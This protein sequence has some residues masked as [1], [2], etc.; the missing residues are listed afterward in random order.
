M[1]IST[2]WN[3][4]VGVPDGLFCSKIEAHSAVVDDTAMRLE[5]RKELSLLKY[6]I[7]LGLFTYVSMTR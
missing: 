6:Y 7:T 3:E 4:A 1:A 5:C 2:G